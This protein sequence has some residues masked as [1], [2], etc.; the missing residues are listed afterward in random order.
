MKRLHRGRKALTDYGYRDLS[1]LDEQS[2]GEDDQASSGIL[3][4]LEVNLALTALYAV[5]EA[6]RREDDTHKN[7][8]IDKF[9]GITLYT[10]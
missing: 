7:E 1:A 10:A 2:D 8:L 5:V 9:L 6:G 3:I 4:E